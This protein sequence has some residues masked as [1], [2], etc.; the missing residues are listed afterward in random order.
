MLG[1]QMT[2]PDLA[3]VLGVALVLLA[4]ALLQL[5]RVDHRAPIYSAQNLVGAALILYSL[6]YDFNLPSALIE[7]AWALISAFGL[8]LALRRR[9][10]AR[11]A[12][13]PAAPG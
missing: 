6:V 8:L 10:A 7:G 1:A 13:A 12:A 2:L 5:G 4:Y 11:A 3:G 9:R